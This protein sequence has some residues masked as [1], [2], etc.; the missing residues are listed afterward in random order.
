MNTAAAAELDKYPKYA[1]LYKMAFKK[2]LEANKARG[3]VSRNGWKT[4]EDV[5]EWWLNGSKKKKLN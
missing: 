1:N 4:P 5:M 3:V 2:M